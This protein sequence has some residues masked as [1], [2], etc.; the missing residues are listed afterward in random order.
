MTSTPAMLA[1]EQFAGAVGSIYLRTRLMSHPGFARP[2]AIYAVF[3]ADAQQLTLVAVIDDPALF[4]RA[5][6]SL[7]RIVD[8]LNETDGLERGLAVWW[9]QVV[10]DEPQD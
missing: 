2:W 4:V 10:A 6:E 8:H 7:R 1:F 3:D 9:P 5:R